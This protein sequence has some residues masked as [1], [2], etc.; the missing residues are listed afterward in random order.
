[1]QENTCH[2]SVLLNDHG[3]II[4][5]VIVSREAEETFQM[6]SNAATVD[7]VRRLL[8]EQQAKYDVSVMENDDALV[9]LQGRCGG[10]GTR[11]G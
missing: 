6:V 7:R 1:M 3:G 5:D 10:E 9:A 8:R 2:Y 4:D 11:L